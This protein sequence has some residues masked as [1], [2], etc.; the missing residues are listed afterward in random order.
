MFISKPDHYHRNVNES[1]KLKARPALLTATDGSQ[2][3]AVVIQSAHFIK[4]LLPTREALRIANEI[5]DAV[6]EAERNEAA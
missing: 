1:Q 6:E 2:E 4:Y 5:A 3:P